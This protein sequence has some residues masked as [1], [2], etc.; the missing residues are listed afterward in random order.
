MAQEI[1]KPVEYYY[2]YHPT[3][4]D[5]MGETGWHS[6]LIRYLSEV[7]SWLFHDQVCAIYENLNFY[8]TLNPRERPVTPDLA[9]IKGVRWKYVRSWSPNR[10]GIPPHVVFEILSDETWQKDLYE[11]P[12][13]YASLGV[14]EYFA[15]DPNEPSISRAT[16]RRLSGWQLD[17]RHKEMIEMTPDKQG[18]LWSEQ[19]QCW[20]VAEGPYLRL[21]NHKYQQCLTE[22]QAEALLRKQATEQA[23]EQARR[24]EAFAAKLRS[25]GINPDEVI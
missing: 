19:L 21:Y 3:E 25:L 4:E 8:Q 13:R 12:T 1:S 7:L 14:Q 18:R 23:E 9:V 20:L 16:A 10:I 17:A 6:R 5:L 11:K 15:Y 24:A 22:A 2:D